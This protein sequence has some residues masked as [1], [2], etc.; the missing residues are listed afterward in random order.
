[1]ATGVKAESFKGM[2]KLTEKSFDK[3]E[4]AGP[5]NLNRIK[6]NDLTVHGPMEFEEIT[7]YGQAQITGPMRGK[8]GNFQTMETTGPMHTEEMSAH[9]LKATGPTKLE[10]FTFTGNV[11]VNGPLEAKKGQF[12]DLTVTGSDIELEDIS[13]KN[14]TLADEEKPATVTLKGK[15]SVAGN[16][17]FKSG[18]GIVKKDD[19]STIEG[20]IMGG[21]L[22]R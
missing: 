20:K 22:S 12:N 19:Q 5:A 8:R 17:V 18:K 3:L 11:A 15:A 14:L 2:T 13:L 21:S 16:I 10:K 6:T 1:V 7:V 9:T 4:I